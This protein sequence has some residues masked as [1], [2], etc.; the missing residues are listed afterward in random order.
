VFSF[1]VVVWEVVAREIPHEKLAPLE[2]AMQVVYENLRL[3]IPE[4]CPELLSQLMQDCWK[5]D[6]AERPDFKTIV[7]RLE[8]VKEVLK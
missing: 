1:G 8:K 4:N 3:K 2:V 6:P 5:A 7:S